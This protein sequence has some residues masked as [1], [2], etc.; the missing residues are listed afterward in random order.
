MIQPIQMP[1]ADL[2]AIARY[3]G[4]TGKQVRVLWQ[5]DESLAFVARGRD[6]RSEFH[7]NPSDELMY[8]IAGTMR[9]HYRTPEWKEE[10][11][12]LT[13]VARAASD[14]DQF[15]GHGGLLEMSAQRRRAR[16]RLV[17]SGDRTLSRIERAV[18]RAPSGFRAWRRQW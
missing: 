8:Q 12:V 18:R 10:V 13:K 7:I 14:D 6:Y 11:A 17:Q 15:S 2:R 5:E 3:L 9:L 16:A 4:A 1:I